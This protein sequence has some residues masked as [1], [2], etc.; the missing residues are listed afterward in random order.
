[1]A[2]PCAISI[3]HVA[4]QSPQASPT[5]MQPQLSGTMSSG[6]AP[7]QGLSAHGLPKA[8]PRAARCSRDTYGCCKTHRVSTMGCGGWWLWQRSQP[9]TVPESTCGRTGKPNSSRP[10]LMDSPSSHWQKPTGELASCRCHQ[11]H[12]ELLLRKP[13]PGGLWPTQQPPLLT[14]STQ[15]SS[16]MGGVTSSSPTTVLLGV[17]EREIPLSSCPLAGL[18]TPVTLTF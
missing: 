18:G 3:V 2:L 4:G 1:M 14:L 9:S 11:P 15:G 8:S 7:Q 13:Q 5:R 10:L 17:G 12:H 16:H 6:S